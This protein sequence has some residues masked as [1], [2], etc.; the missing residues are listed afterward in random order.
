MKKIILNDVFPNHRTKYKY[1][2]AFYEPEW[3]EELKRMFGD[4]D[5]DEGIYYELNKNERKE[6]VSTLSSD[7]TIERVDKEFLENKSYIIP[8]DMRY[9]EQWINNMWGSLKKYD[10]RGFAYSIVHKKK[11]V[12]CFCHC[13]YLSNDKSRSELGILTNKDFQRRGLGKNLVFHVLDQCWEVG[14]KTAGWHTEK[15]NIASRKLAESV[16]YKCNRKYPI[17]YGGWPQEIQIPL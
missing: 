5:T 14:V 6:W 10:K 12:V 1:F 8:D 2:L 13:S 17:Y 11:L 15:E 7:F 9:I 16:G 4:L 3:S